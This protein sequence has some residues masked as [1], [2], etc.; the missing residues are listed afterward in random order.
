VEKIKED[1][2]VALVIH[3][4]T[5]QITGENRVYVVV[6]P[7]VFSNSQPGMDKLRRHTY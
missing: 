2:I 7:T 6:R 3:M 4:K 5:H 1:E